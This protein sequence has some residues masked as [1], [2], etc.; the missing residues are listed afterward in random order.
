MTG[1]SILE[2]VHR[3][4]QQEVVQQFHLTPPTWMITSL[5]T[6][7]PAH[8][9]YSEDDECLDDSRATRASSLSNGLLS[10]IMFFIHCSSGAADRPNYGSCLS[11]CLSVAYGLIS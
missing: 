4:D 2:Y 9:Y 8:L 7:S 11:V 3:L 5:M 10:S 6:S 1:S